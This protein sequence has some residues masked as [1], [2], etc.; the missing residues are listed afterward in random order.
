MDLQLKQMIASDL[1]L[2]ALSATEQDAAIERVGKIIFQSVLLR[3]SETLD[4]TDQK[5]LEKLLGEP[6]SDP[7]ALFAFLGEKAPN[8]NEIVKEEVLRFKE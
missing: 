3:V 1:G 7:S 2:G 6:A 8:L 5:A 4:E